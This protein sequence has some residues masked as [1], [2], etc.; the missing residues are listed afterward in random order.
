MVAEAASEL[1]TAL[2]PP[3]PPSSPPQA[4][5][6]PLD[7]DRDTVPAHQL[8]RKE[9][10]DSERWLLLRT[11]HLL[12]KAN[13]SHLSRSKLLSL[14][15]EHDQDGLLVSVDPEEYDTLQMWTR[16]LSTE[17]RS[18]L[19]R[20]RR[21][22][23]SL[24]SPEI[25]REATQ[26]VYKRVFV[27][28]RFRG[29]HTLHLK[30]FKEVPCDQLEY[31][32]PNGKVRMSRVDK[33]FLGSSVLLGVATFALRYITM[34]ADYAAWT[35]LAA[36]AAGLVAGR[37]W[38]RYRSK[39]DRY[40]LNLSNM[41]YYRSL[42]HNRSV[43]TLLADRA[44]EEE[45]K[46][47]LL[48]YVFLLSPRNRRGVPGTAHTATPP[49]PDTAESLRQR[50]EAWLVREW[51]V[52]GVRFDVDDALGK[53]RELGV[54]EEGGGGGRLSVRGVEETLAA[55]PQPSLAWSAVTHLREEG[56]LGESVEAGQATMKRQSH[57]S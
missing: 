21:A 26:A 41:L 44:M 7:P 28:V 46:E 29:S 9:L 33:L 10:L 31:L 52:E 57:W 12:E 3:P 27:A 32:L 23:L 38:L 8:S 16:G 55:L 37:A 17:Q 30:L 53:L 35:S 5:Y 36:V 20:L 22:F 43:L 47:A 1:F 50:V 42:A 13:F 4:L 40:L 6:D 45:F 11:H 56:L 39:R 18:A 51:G 2:T 25:S 14:L 24:F 19:Q 48:G 34:L 54:L 49:L 15:Q